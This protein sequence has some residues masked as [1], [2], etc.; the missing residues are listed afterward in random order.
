M[1]NSMLRNRLRNVRCVAAAMLSFACVGAVP[2]Q[3][4][5]TEVMSDTG[6]NENVWEWVELL[7][8]SAAAVDLNGWVFDDDD[9]NSLNGA[10]INNSTGSTIIPAGGVAVLYNAAASALNAT[11]ARFTN[12]WGGPITLIGVDPFGGGLANSGDAIGLWSTL[13]SY[14]AD[15]LMVTSGT[16]RTFNS[17]VTSLDFSPTAGFPNAANGR[18]LAWNGVGSATDPTQWVV[19]IDGELGARTSSATTLNAG[20]VNN[21]SDRATPGVPPT[22]PAGPGLSITEIMYDPASPEPAWEWIE[23][24][25]NTGAPIDFS[26]T[27]AVL[28]DDDDA[29][30]AMPNLTTGAI[31]QGG[32][33]VLFNAAANS[34]TD[35]RAAWGET[36]NFI[37]VST[38][39]DLANGGDLVAI[40]PSLAAYNAAALTGTMSPRRTTDGTLASVLYDDND[41]IGW[42]NNDGSHS[43]ELVSGDANPAEPTSWQLSA[44]GPPMQVTATLPDHPGGDVGSPGTVPGAAS[45]VAGDYNAN[46]S[47]DAADYVL[48]RNGGPL[49]NEG[50]MPGTV[51]QADYDFWRARFGATAG[52]GGAVDAAAVPEPAGFVM[53][54]CALMNCAALRRTCRVPRSTRPPARSAL[55]SRPRFVAT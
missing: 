17:A 43:I 48:W 8:T 1:R 30:L 40:W 16:R 46:G 54:M 9:D 33:A 47:V 19:S 55:R 31:D 51:N 24:H 10:N 7:N 25:N 22:G 53:A 52:S 34:L 50:D 28:D 26:L 27:S 12:A 35:M 39:T 6:A 3:V 36:V 18:S 20:P 41:M 21:T 29:H 32:T 14:Q 23:V 37:P 5:I 44:G 42:P 49:Q 15:D 13:S 11:P 4:V 2:A 38:W 45:G